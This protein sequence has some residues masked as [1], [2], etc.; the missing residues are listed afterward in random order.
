MVICD[1]CKKDPAE[2]ETNAALKTAPW[3]IVV[4]PPAGSGL[5]ERRYCFRCTL[6]LFDRLVGSK[7]FQDGEPP[8]K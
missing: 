5:P 1:R 3:G 8:P 6:A 2:T 7:P 4:S